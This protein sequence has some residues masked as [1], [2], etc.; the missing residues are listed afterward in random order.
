M[1]ANLQ[2]DAIVFATMQKES[3]LLQRFVDID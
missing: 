2:Q 3:R 1:P